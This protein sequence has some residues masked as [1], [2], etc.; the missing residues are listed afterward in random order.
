M[1]EKLMTEAERHLIK[2]AIELIR[3]DDAKFGPSVISGAVE[4]LRYAIRDRLREIDQKPQWCMVF[5]TAPDGQ[6][7]GGKY[8][9]N[10]ALERISF[11]VC[12]L[13]R[14]ICDEERAQEKEDKKHHDRY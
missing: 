6:R 14:C 7:Y 4:R 9:W 2:C 13:E 5:I 3:E 8:L 1:E 11:P 12:L 10:E